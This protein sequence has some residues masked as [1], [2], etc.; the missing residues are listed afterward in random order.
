MGYHQCNKCGAFDFVESHKCLPIYSVVIDKDYYVAMEE[1]KWSNVGAIGPDYAAE[2]FLD[3]M[4]ENYEVCNSSITVRVRD[5][6]TQEH[7][8]WEVYG[9]PRIDFSAT[10]VELREAT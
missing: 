1:S 8:M 4:D 5:N 3:R 9:E 2:T 10:S 6:T 7:T